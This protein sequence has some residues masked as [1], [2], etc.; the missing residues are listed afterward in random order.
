[1]DRPVDAPILAKPGLVGQ[2]KTGTETPNLVVWEETQQKPLL[3]GK[4]HNSRL[5]G[6]QK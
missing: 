1:M 5:V 2:Q 3:V 6:V 4:G